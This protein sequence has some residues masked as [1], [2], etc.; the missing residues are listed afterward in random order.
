MLNWANQEQI[1][2][3]STGELYMDMHRY[4]LYVSALHP[5]HSPLG[6]SMDIVFNAFYLTDFLFP[7][8]LW[9]FKV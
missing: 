6:R 4:L 3:N 7:L 1:D 9:L 2:H 5:V 8:Q